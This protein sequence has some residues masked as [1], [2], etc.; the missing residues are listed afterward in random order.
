[1]VIK[2]K[3]A[4]RTPNQQDQKEIS[5]LNITVKTLSIQNK[6]RTLKTA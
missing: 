2:V 1:M 5:P 4:F 6:E 3:E